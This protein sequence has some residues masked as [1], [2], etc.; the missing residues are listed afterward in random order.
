MA[1]RAHAAPSP[2]SARPRT[3]PPL[4]LPRLAC[5]PEHRPP[6]QVM[7]SWSALQPSRASGGGR[8]ASTH[9]CRSCPPL[10]AAAGASCSTPAR[11]PPQRPP[12]S[13]AIHMHVYRMHTSTQPRSPAGCEPGPALAKDNIICGG[14]G[15]ATDRPV[16][17]GAVRSP[18]RRVRAPRAAR[19]HPALEVRA[20]AHASVHELW[21]LWMWL[22]V[23]VSDVRSRR[24]SLERD[25]TGDDG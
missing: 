17:R 19:G 18:G 15:K 1:F 3:Y 8:R 10:S 16:V 5:L 24:F 11:R 20:R 4:R 23:S 6:R 12:R 25:R 14:K 7:S 9:G 21:L 2:P 13:P 22:L